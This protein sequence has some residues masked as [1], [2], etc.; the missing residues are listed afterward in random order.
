MIPCS[1]VVVVV[2]A[3]AIGALLG[4]DSTK[5]PPAAEPVAQQNATTKQ[6]RAEL[7]P[8]KQINTESD[9]E[10]S[11][12]CRQY[13]CKE[14]GHWDVQNGKMNHTYETTTNHVSVEV[15]TAAGNSVTGFGLM[16]SERDRLSDEDLSAI[17]TLTR[18]VDQ[19]VGHDKTISFIK[20]N[21]EVKVCSTCQVDQSAKSIK[22]GNF[23]IWAG[24]SGTDQVVSFKRVEPKKEEAI[25]TALP[26][27]IDSDLLAR[28]DRLLAG[29][30]ISD[31]SPDHEAEAALYVS[32]FSRRHPNSNSQ[33]FKMTG[34]RLAWVKQARDQA[35]QDAAIDTKDTRG[36]A[37]DMCRATVKENLKAPSSADFQ[38]YRD[39]YIGYMGKGKFQV[40]TKADAVNSFGAKLRS[41]FECEVQCTSGGDC[42]VT[43]LKE[44]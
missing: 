26:S 16:F 23:R 36:A 5:T 6:Q 20:G 32:E 14:S 33:H 13:H 30:S 38:S 12:F 40:R 7:P 9:F 41:T 37:Q 1:K 39:D 15:Q 29:A 25:Y 44:M 42:A 28:A 11:E 10:S 3:F 43:G 34:A 8:S 19:S 24:K 2:L 17:G 27:L 22:D 35:Y 4:C 21:V 18:S 31:I